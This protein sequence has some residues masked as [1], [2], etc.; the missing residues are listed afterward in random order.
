M[1]FWKGQ[2]CNKRLQSKPWTGLQRNICTSGKINSVRTDF[3]LVV[4][5]GMTVSQ[6][7]GETAYLN[8]EL[9]EEV[10]MEIQE[11]TEEALKIIFK[12]KGKGSKI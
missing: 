11:F 12:N 2:N 5:Y 6:T 8:G 4:E 7:D 9:E 3:A 1:V 10:F